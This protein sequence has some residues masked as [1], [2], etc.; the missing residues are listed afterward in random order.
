M[1]SFLETN[2]DEDSGSEKSDGVKG[3]GCLISLVVASCVSPSL[4]LSLRWLSR[5]KWKDLSVKP[6]VNMFQI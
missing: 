5:A 6:H 4:I 3:G 2:N 1:I